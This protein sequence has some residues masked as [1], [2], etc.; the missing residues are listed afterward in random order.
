MTAYLL[1][2]L[3]GGA[4]PR[5][6]SPLRSE[7]RLLWWLKEFQRK[8]TSKVIATTNQ[9]KV[10]IATTNRHAATGTRQPA[11]SDRDAVTGTQQP[12]RS[13]QQHQQPA[14]SNNQ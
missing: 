3:L 13:D 12:A 9:P 4:P 14:T 8:I 7:G 10:E 5:G 1:E 6:Y 11:C 2:Y